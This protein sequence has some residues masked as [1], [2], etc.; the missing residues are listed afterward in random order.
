[1]KAAFD[2]EAFTTTFNEMSFKNISN[3]YTYENVT[4]A[5]V[6]YFNSFTFHFKQRNTQNDDDFDTY[7]EFMTGTFANK[8]KDEKVE[9]N[10]KDITI[11]GDKV[12]LLIDDS[13][14][15]GLKMLEL[16]NGL[17]E[18]YKMFIPEVVVNKLFEL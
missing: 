12:I 13:N 8:H 9:R 5:N 11:S 16:Q 6:N 17:A 1:M 2:N 15:N 3:A 4:Y 10:G 14:A 7:M 18:I